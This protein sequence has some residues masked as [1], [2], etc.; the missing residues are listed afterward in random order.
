MRRR[1]AAASAPPVDFSSLGRRRRCF[2]GCDRLRGQRRPRQAD[3]ELR[4]AQP[5]LLRPLIV[6]GSRAVVF[7]QLQ[8]LVRDS[9]QSD[10]IPRPE[11]LRWSEAERI[12][13]ALGI[14]R[15]RPEHIGNLCGAETAMKGD[16]AQV[17]AMQATG[18]LGEY[19]VFGVG[20]D[21]FDDQLLPC[22]AQRESRPIL[23][24]TL[25]AASHPRRRRGKRRVPLRIHRMLMEGDRELD[26]E[27]GQLPGQRGCHGLPK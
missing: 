18:E 25:G 10:V 12:A 6:E 8:A 7:L 24:Q 26:Q 21:A 14:D 15:E 20:G 19:G 22:Y 4:T 16:R 17:M 1:S 5:A 27:I 9:M 2:V 23:E 11:L 13:R 3:P